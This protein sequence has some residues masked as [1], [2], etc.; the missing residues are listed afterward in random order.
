MRREK[1]QNLI[2]EIC[3]IWNV[4]ACFGA[5]PLIY[6]D[7]DTQDLNRRKNFVS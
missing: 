5:L 1:G 3:P 2:F 4:I 6:V 7:D